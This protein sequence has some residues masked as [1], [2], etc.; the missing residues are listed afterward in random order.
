MH[1]LNSVAGEY[2]Y[3]VHIVIGCIVALL[4]VIPD[5][6]EETEELEKSISK[7][8]TN[9]RSSGVE[10]KENTSSASEKGTPEIDIVNISDVAFEEF[11]QFRFKSLKISMTSKVE[12]L[13]IEIFYILRTIF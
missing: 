10:N 12:N 3:L 8:D 9:K 13:K 1:L 5:I 7:L 4:A 6:I 11:L 2:A